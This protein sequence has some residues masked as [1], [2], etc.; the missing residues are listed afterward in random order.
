MRYLEEQIYN[1]NAKEDVLPFIKRTES[2][3]IWNADFFSQIAE[4][5]KAG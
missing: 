4:T 2:L 5:L 1:N 3:E